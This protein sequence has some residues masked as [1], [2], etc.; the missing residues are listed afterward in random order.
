[1]GGSSEVGLTNRTLSITADGES[2]RFEEQGG[3]RTRPSDVERSQNTSMK[4]SGIPLPDMKKVA[5]AQSVTGSL[6][7]VALDLKS[8]QPDL[9]E[10]ISMMEGSGGA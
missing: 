2:Y 6:G 1:V 7:G 8:S 5:M 3:P 9:K 4:V 10:F